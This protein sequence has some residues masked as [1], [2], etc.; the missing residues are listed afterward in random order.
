VNTVIGNSH[1]RDIEIAGGDTAQPLNLRKRLRLI[2][3]HVRLAGSRILDAGCG[4]GEYVSAM[5]ELGADA[6]GIEYEHSKVESWR[7]LHP[8]DKRV[9]QGDLEQ[10][11]V[12]EASVDAALL[13]EVLEHVPNEAA[14]LQQIHRALRPGGVLIIFAPNRRYPFETHGFDSRRTARRIAPARTFGLPWLPVKWVARFVRPWARNYWPYE[15]RR[16]L[17]DAGFEII[18]TDYV[19]Q[20]FENISGTQP[21]VIARLRPALRALAGILE[22]APLIRSFGVSQVVIARK[23]AL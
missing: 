21:T 15:L 4:A 7:R 8:G 16:L 19:W 14:A 20:T 22:R 1:Y 9:C 13:N 3:G 18:G 5:S 23:P 17:T 2:Q 11:R 10:L 12:E 6:F